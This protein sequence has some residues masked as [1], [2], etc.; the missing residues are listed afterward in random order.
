MKQNLYCSIVSNQKY[1]F[2]PI[3]FL[4]S[5]GACTEGDIRLI[6]G[7]SVLE[8]RVEV[9]VNGVWG[10]VQHRGFKSVAAKVACQ[11]LGYID[12]CKNIKI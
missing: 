2:E 7:N 6:G 8:G 10:T 1:T 11:Q 9:C 5:A 12:G 3:F 4:F